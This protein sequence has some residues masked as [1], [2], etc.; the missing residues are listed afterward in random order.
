MSSSHKF[1]FESL[2]HI[3][4]NLRDTKTFELARIQKEFQLLEDRLHREQQEISDLQAD[5]KRSQQKGELDV[6][7]LIRFR[8]RQ[9]Y[10]IGK[11]KETESEMHLLQEKV[12]EKR[13]EL[14]NAV[15]DVKVLENLRDK[16]LENHL[17][18]ERLMES[19]RI[20]DFVGL[21]EAAHRQK[22]RSEE[23]LN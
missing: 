6:D 21:E 18:N 2:L 20:D 11:K 15:R 22:N 23:N 14:D 16:D 12:D 4:E 13:K 8:N 3:R 5:W 19:N 1:R 10:L 7:L 17:A 9:D